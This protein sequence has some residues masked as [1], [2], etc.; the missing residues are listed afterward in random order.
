MPWAAGAPCAELGKHRVHTVTAEIPISHRFE[1]A[2][3]QAGEM[4]NVF[5]KESPGPLI[6]S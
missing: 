4:K 6:G 3:T 2:L 1:L 5:I